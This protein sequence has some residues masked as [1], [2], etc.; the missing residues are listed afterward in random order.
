MI[1][2]IAGRVCIPSEQQNAFIDQREEQAVG[3]FIY[4][5]DCKASR[6]GQS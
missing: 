4:G 2:G 6:R 1:R 3:V 5:G